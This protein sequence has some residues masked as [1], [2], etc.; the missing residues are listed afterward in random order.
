MM[1]ERM[2][3]PELPEEW[4]VKREYYGSADLH[5]L[6]EERIFRKLWQFVGLESEVPKPGDFKRAAIAGEPLLVV[7]G[8][9]GAVRVF[10]NSCRHRG[11]IV[12]ERA[13]GHAELFRCAY[14][15]WCYDNRGR[16]MQVTMPSAYGSW[17]Q[18]ES[19]GLTEVP[20]QEVFRGLI[21]A[22]L[23]RG[24]PPLKDCLGAAAGH[25]D[26]AMTF[27]GAPLEFVA[28]YS[29]RIRANWKLFMENTVEGYHPYYLHAAS[30]SD[31]G[32]ASHDRDRGGRTVDL[33]HHAL[34][35][36]G[37]LQRREGSVAGRL[38]THVL[39]FPNCLALHHEP[40]GPFAIRHV[41]PER[42]DRTTISVYALAPAGEARPIRLERLKHFNTS[43]GPGGRNGADDNHALELVQE[44]LK[45]R[46]G[47]EVLI[48]RGAE[49]AAAGGVADENSLRAFWRGW[50]HYVG[51]VQ[52][53]SNRQST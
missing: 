40:A 10:Y 30:L 34:W 49:G 43:W 22:S 42:V 32:G 21:F 5:L 44:G 25:L 31:H 2:L 33:G 38:L 46:S 29:Y 18:K 17:F 14:H 7:R 12:E 6:E 19:Y 15:H 20:R 11:A 51:A 53:P 35:E 50:R 52:S 27:S 9:D 4:R 36:S 13:S 48:A 45:A 8:E 3:Q 1:N 39:L 24:A 37:N 26:Y 41:V 28:T 47:A 23:D 16:L